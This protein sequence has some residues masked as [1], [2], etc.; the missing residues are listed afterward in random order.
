MPACAELVKATAPN[1][2]TTKTT[3]FTLIPLPICHSTRAGCPL[4]INLLTNN[5]ASHQNIGAVAL[6]RYKPFHG[7]Q[8][9]IDREGLNLVRRLPGEPL[10]ARV[11][12]RIDL[13][14]ANEPSEKDDECF[15][16]ELAIALAAD[17]ILRHKAEAVDELYVAAIDA[18][19]FTQLAK[20][21]LQLALSRINMPLGKI[22]SVSMAH[23]QEFSDRLAANDQ[24]TAG[25]HFR[26]DKTI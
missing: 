3:F 16:I 7:R 17:L 4:A 25:L 11:L 23:Q 24:K 6:S 2:A 15:V 26:H 12:G 18:G 22:P 10:V 20:G 13:Y 5:T 21:T 1:T 14:I 8:K 9:R 19:F